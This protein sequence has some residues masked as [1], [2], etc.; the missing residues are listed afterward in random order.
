MNAADY[1]A[2]DATGL[3]ALVRSRAVTATDLLDLALSRIDADPGINAVVHRYDDTARR[4]IAHGL[5]D[6]PF[7]GV[8]FLVKGTGAA[9]AG[10]EFSNG[11]ALLRGSVATVDSVLAARQLAAGLVPLGRTNVPEFALSFTTE[12]EAFG[13]TRNPWD[14]TRSPG[15]SS[16]GSAAAV[17]AGMVPMAHASDGAGS[18]RVPAAHCGLF[19][20]KPSRMRNPM[21]PDVAEGVAGMGTPH[22]VTRSVRDSAR[23]LDATSGPDIGDPYAVPPPAR[24]FADELARPPVPLRI[25]LLGAAASPV[26][27]DPACLE[28]LD[29]AAR[30][31][32][33]L[34]HHVEPATLPHDAEGLRH[35]WR[36]IAGVNLVRPVLA[37]GKRRHLPDPLAEIEPVNAEWLQ[38]G[39]GWTGEDYL[40]AIAQLHRSSRAMGSFFQ[41]HDILLSP[42]TATP[43]PI[44]GQ[45]AG[46]A[47]S[48]DAFFQRFW[49]HA[50]FTPIFNASGCPAMSVPLGWPPSGLPI[51]VQ[52][53]AAF[54][55]DGLLFA[56]ASQLE[57]AQPWFHRRPPRT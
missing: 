10:A 34:G 23:L 57:Q 1:E 19:G 46:H 26:P 31:C 22:A 6:G 50:P 43:P 33:S 15:G 40:A 4:R 53:G 27:I 11:S 20:F 39:Q 28:A 36:V 7:T 8:P 16:G 56:L 52:F 14:R 21:G 30:L 49:D 17:A 18:T 25:G 37:E 51:G 24:P 3:A 29:A 35:A 5:P 47:L 44:L 48:L 9:L 45:L 32:Q 12:P 42:V 2:H 54:G 38:E 41:R 13:P 55:Q